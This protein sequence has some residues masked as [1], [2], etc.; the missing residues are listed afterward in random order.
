M[1]N[2]VHVRRHYG[3]ENARPLPEGAQLA[4]R[5]EVR[6]EYQVEEGVDDE[7]DVRR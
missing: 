2:S 1:V 6:S 7:Q 5:V 3:A 4:E